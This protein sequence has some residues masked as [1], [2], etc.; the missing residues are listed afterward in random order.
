MAISLELGINLL[1]NGGLSSP[2]FAGGFYVNL[3]KDAAYPNW[4]YRGISQRDLIGLQ[5]PHGLKQCRLEIRTYGS[6]AGTGSD[7]IDLAEQ[8]FNILQGFKGF[9]PEGT[10]VDSIFRD[11]KVD[12]PEDPF[13]RNFIRT[14]EFLVSFY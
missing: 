5:T 12:N 14:Q 10:Q 3:P 13:A 6:P 9:L 11:D 2:P 4:T 8:I 7:S 1:V